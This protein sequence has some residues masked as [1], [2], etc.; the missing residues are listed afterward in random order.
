MPTD[1]LAIL[2]DVLSTFRLGFTRPGFS[3]FLVFAAGWI[4]TQGP[5]HCVTETLVVTDVAHQRH[6]AAYHRFFSRGTWD[7]ERLGYWLLQRLRPWV[8]DGVLR[9]AIDDTLCPHKGPA[10]FGLGTHLD[11]VRSTR[12]HKLFAFGHAWGGQR[13]DSCR[14]DAISRRTTPS[15]AERRWNRPAAEG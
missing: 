1:P 7:P 9:L 6:W 14:M 11:A 10:I 3:K 5:M 13:Q 15:F 4:L 12:K 2:Q 8:R